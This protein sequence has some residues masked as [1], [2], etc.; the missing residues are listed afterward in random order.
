MKKYTLVFGLILATLLAVL[1]GQSAHALD[2]FTIK[3]YLVEMEL[4]RDNEG[5]STLRTVETIT[6]DFKQRNENHGLERVFVKEY[7]GHKTSLKLESVTDE[8]GNELSYHW[9]GD[10]LRIGDAD[11]YVYG[12]KTYTIV[13]TQRDV[14]RYFI[15]T[16]K[17]EFYWDVFGL[18]W[19][20]PIE[21]AQFKLMLTPELQS[22]VATQMYCYVGYEGSTNQCQTSEEEGEYLASIDNIGLRKGMTISLGFESATF[23]SYEKSLFDKLLEY[24]ILSLIVTALISIPLTIASIYL[25]RRWKFRDS[26]LGSIAPEY[27]PPKNASVAVAAAVLPEPIATPAAQLTDLAVRHYIQILET[28]PKAS[29]W[30]QAEYDIEI[31]KE[32]DT[33]RAEEQ[34][35]LKDMFGFAPQVGGRMALKDLQ[36]NSSAYIRFSDNDKKLANL[37]RNQY[38]FKQIDQSRR[39]WFGRFA[40]IILLASI[41]TLSPFL[42]TTAIIAFIFSKTLWVLSDDGLALRRYLKGLEMYITVAEKDRLAMLQS[43]EGAE[44]VGVKNPTDP[45]QIVKLYE[46]VLPYAV[47]FKQE[48]EW[49]KRLGEYYDRLESKPDW[50]T[51]QTAFN[52]AVFSTMMS[53]FTTSVTASSASS[54]SGGSSGGGSAGGGG[55]GGGGGGW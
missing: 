26:E 52:A 36:N 16:D 29:F 24:W 42:L 5:R 50:Y 14:T 7:D 55:G 45:A 30:R 43:P 17:D 32:I 22:A 53:S 51:G 15:D 19:R 31:I 9:S 2:N 13:Y 12:E 27:L 8:N 6:A 54:S 39:N 48:K 40:K 4:G 49:G 1:L 33:L 23:A 11:T 10:A 47:L 35:I 25:Y 21:N 28:K 34:E 41:L 37:M 20:V 18:E 38:G 3:N 46:K 44:K